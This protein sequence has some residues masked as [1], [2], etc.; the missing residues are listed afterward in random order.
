[1]FKNMKYLLIVMTLFVCGFSFSYNYDKVVQSSST[2][3]SKASCAPASANLT[4]K[5]NDVS[6]RLET[7]GMLFL[8]RANGRA[9]YEVPKG[10]GNTAIYAA[11]L[12]MGG[13]DVN[14]QLKLAAQ[15]YRSSG[16]DFWTGPLSTFGGDKGDYDPSQPVGDGAVHGYGDANIN[17][18]Q[19][20]AYDK[21][22][23][24]RKSEVIQFITWKDCETKK[25]DNCESPSN[26]VLNRIYA[27]PAHGDVSA[28]QDH[29]LA[30]FK[31][32]NNN[33][34][35]EP[36]LGDYP[37]YDDILGRDDI[38]CGSD[39][40]IS[41]FGDETHWWVF[42]DKGNIHTETGGDPIGMEI[43]AQAFSFA[44]SD[45]VNRM[46][47]YN[48][49]LIN[50]GTQTLYNTYFSQYVDADLGGATDDYVG[51]DVTRGL[52][53]CYNGDNYDDNYQSS[54]GYGSLPPAIGVDFF[55]G[56]YQDADNIDNPGPKD[57]TI[58]KITIVPTVIDAIENKGIVYAGLGIGYGDGIID[59]ERYGM[60]RFT[61]YTAQASQ[62]QSDP[63]SAAQYYNYMNGKWRFG[64]KMVYGG[65][66]FPNSPGATTIK[67]D[68]MFPD[69][70]DTLDWGTGGVD[71][72]MKSWS[73]LTKPNQPQDRRFVQSAGPFTLRPGAVNN[74][75]VGIVYAR[76]AEGD[77]MA[78]VRAL[79]RADTKAQSLFDNCFKLLE[80]PSAPK[81]SIQELDK[82]VVLT[83]SN[84]SSSN[85]F[86]EKYK[87]LDFN[88]VSTIDNK[89]TDRYYR[90]EGYLIYQMKDNTGSVADVTNT[91]KARLVAQC[92][93]KNGISRIVNFEFDEELGFSLP[94]EKVSGANSGLKHSF[95]VTSDQF[96]K[97]SLVNNKSYYYIAVAYAYNSFKKY[98]PNDPTALDGQKTPFIMSRNS[99]DG[100]PIVASLAIPHNTRAENIEKNSNYGSTPK[101]TRIDGRG[102]GNRHLELTEESKNKI[103]KTGFLTTP[104][105]DNGY[106][107][108]S[109]KVVDPLSLKGG[110]YTCKFNGYVSDTSKSYS[111]FNGSSIDTSSWTI[112]RF[113]KEGGSI[114]D[115]VTS[116]ETI[117]SDNEQI[118]PDWGISVEIFQSK[119]YFATSSYSEEYRRYSDP[120]SSSITFA[121]S[122]K[123]WL[124]FVKDDNSFSPNNWIRSGD[125]VPEANES[126]PELGW[127]NPY[128]YA[129]EKGL[130]PEK[131]YS[132]LI[133][134]GIAPHCLVGY[135]SEF[136]PL[137]YPS[138]FTKS[139]YSDARNFSSISRLT[140]IDIVITSDTS[141]WT[142]CPVIELGRH[143]SLN[144]G[145]AEA[146]TLRRGISV[147]KNGNQ[148]KDTANNKYARGMGWF[149]GYA[150]DLESGMRLHMAFGENSFLSI[151][152]G[153]DMIWN[154]NEITYDNTGNPHLGGQHPIYIF[155]YNV[156][157]YYSP[158]TF[159][160]CPYYDGVNN[161]VYDNL[162]L[163]SDPK[164]YERYKDVYHSLQWVVNPVLNSDS[165]LL[166]TNVTLKV[167][168][169][170]EFNDFKTTGLNNGKPMYGWSQ[171]ALASTISS[172]DRK[173]DELSLINVVPNPYYA[174][175]AYEAYSS[176]S[177]H[178]LDTRVKITNLP[179]N[180][181]IK[182]F[183]ISGK[184]IWS[185]KKASKV[186]YVDWDL[187]NTQAIPIASGI[188]L[189]HVDVPGVGST[190][191]K[192]FGGMREV[193][194]EN[195]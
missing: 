166:S 6:A 12:W 82:S 104:T 143:K 102:N 167:R 184:L 10:S 99:Y 28:G 76:S 35:Y 17:A 141:K 187:K 57:D 153:R 18:D 16:N 130:D 54:K 3:Q 89:P 129:D 162:A 156:H 110:Y 106:G 131:K 26:E 164:N 1:M 88:I 175:S 109:V 64:D 160:N 34:E 121:D 111:N 37:W 71:P 158:D 73:E 100:S 145:N 51:C 115:S 119:Y 105:Y 135:Q 170:K 132:S 68:Y 93:I 173:V 70:S 189:I 96:T 36:L 136:M 94:V 42:N 8:D 103:L 144:E 21:F 148:I 161:W 87:E 195:I 49:E 92:D 133:S 194:L 19:C 56:P 113:D 31:D 193:D 152:N 29:Y 95:L 60:K 142:R 53:Y 183:N 139:F 155:G 178:N 124:S 176:V 55:E 134:G 154:P 122:S 79:K 46:T 72:G 172:Q 116:D 149:P 32:V 171:D 61:Y 180:C 62:S 186:N 81:L 117:G 191:V 86:G 80:P 177:R 120:I 168:I 14:N 27:W 146:G 40:R 5:Y 101:I 48:Y 91:D 38:K 69:D 24:I 15:K 65:T 44:T 123:K 165:K 179:E 2:H 174:Y 39:R 181:T 127:E 118:I 128:L 78:S 33:G 58:K 192:F 74:I 47:F 13:T 52:G 59:N 43:R 4:M 63:T 50:R 67:A 190:V 84:P 157:G 188:Y 45:D 150:I 83:L 75:T 20:V 25:Q 22:F 85:N 41:L 147:D 137:A 30:P 125:Y 114:L 140:S 23:T 7:G 77:L 107:P 98:D 97:T 182:I 66:G 9:A 138:F 159:R 126:K 169:N 108:L 163:N 185:F 112:Y 11:S 90:F 151:D